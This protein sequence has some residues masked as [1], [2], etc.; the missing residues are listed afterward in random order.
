M[1]SSEEFCEMLIIYGESG[2]NSKAAERLYRERFPNRR[3]PTST[4]FLR[5]VN[6]ARTTGSLLPNRKGI[7][8]IPTQKRLCWMRLL[9]MVQ[10]ALEVCPAP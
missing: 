3:H 5:L 8:G 1:F 10:G 6:R 4:V 2:R 9:K 7:G